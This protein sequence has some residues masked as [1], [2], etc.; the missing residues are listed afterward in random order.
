VFVTHDIAEALTLAD[1]VG[2]MSAGPHSVITTVINVDLPRPRNLTDP[3]VARI[4]NNI[5]RL[6]APDV[7]RSAERAEEAEIG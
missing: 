5:E 1:R 4:F 3:S 2:M 6:L 7:V